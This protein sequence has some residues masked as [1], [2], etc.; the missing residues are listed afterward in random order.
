MR[1]HDSSEE[2]EIYID[3]HFVEHSNKLIRD[4]ITDNISQR[5]IEEVEAGIREH[6]YD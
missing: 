1:D 3:T 5:K 2:D 4:L 6:R